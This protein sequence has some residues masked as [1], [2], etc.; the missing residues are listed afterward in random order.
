[1]VVE[2]VIFPILELREQLGREVKVIGITESV[3][4]TDVP[5]V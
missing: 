4:E 3:T 1:M 5:R 2:C